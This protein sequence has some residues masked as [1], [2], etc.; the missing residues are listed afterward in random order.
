MLATSAS[1]VQIDRCPTDAI[2]ALL[3]FAKSVFEE[4]LGWKDDRVLDVLEY[5][6]VFVV[7]EVG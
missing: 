6:F 3:G 4:V 5:D 1:I 2:P 7:R